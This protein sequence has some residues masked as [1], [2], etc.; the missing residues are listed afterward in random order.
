MMVVNDGQ[1]ATNGTTDSDYITLDKL[2][3]TN[4]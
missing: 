2:I 4:H 1:E 3:G